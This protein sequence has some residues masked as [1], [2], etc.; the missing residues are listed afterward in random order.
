MSVGTGQQSIKYRVFLWNKT[1]TYQLKTWTWSMWQRG[2]VPCLVDND[3][4]PRVTAGLSPGPELHVEESPPP[5]VTPPGHCHLPDPDTQPRP[6]G[7]QGPRAGMRN[8]GRPRAWARGCLGETW[9]DPSLHPWGGGGGPGRVGGGRGS[10]WIWGGGGGRH[11]QGGGPHYLEAG[12]T[13]GRPHP[14][15]TVSVPGEKEMINKFYES[16]IQF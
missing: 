3:P 7:T 15:R 9:R 12:H 8:R 14:R 11:S 6:G 13:E 16:V 1:V 10:V 5:G 4:S 2:V